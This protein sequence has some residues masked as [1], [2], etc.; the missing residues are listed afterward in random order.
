MERF[1]TVRKEKE[2]EAKAAKKKAAAVKEERGRSTAAVAQTLH[3]EPDR[4]IDTASR[5]TR[6]SQPKSLVS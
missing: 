3:K 4:P 1:E 6:R 2:Q 5:P